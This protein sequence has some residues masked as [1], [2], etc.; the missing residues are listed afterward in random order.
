MSKQLLCSAPPPAGG[1]EITPIR[2]LRLREVCAV[3]GLSRSGIYRHIQSREFPLPV[4]LG[5]AASGW[6]E[7]EVLAWC[8][9][10]IAARNA[11]GRAA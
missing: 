9:A 5:A 10:R 2:F 4:K 11:Q 3:V 7:S 8:A 1:I 6:I